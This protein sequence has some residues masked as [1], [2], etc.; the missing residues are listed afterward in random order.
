[1]LLGSSIR[2]N[3]LKAFRES[4]RLVTETNFPSVCRN[5]HYPAAVLNA[6]GK[7]SGMICAGLSIII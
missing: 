6:A 4:L 7:V 1:M 5:F 2:I 3:R